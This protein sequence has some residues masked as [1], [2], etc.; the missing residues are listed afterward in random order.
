MIGYMIGLL[1]MM[2]GMVGV[3]LAQALMLHK[4]IGFQ[5][6]VNPLFKIIFNL[7]LIPIFGLMGISLA[8]S[9]MNILATII[10][11]VGLFRYLRMMPK[12][13]DFVPY[14]KIAIGLLG[15]SGI[16]Y[17]LKRNTVITDTD[18]GLEVGYMLLTIFIG[19][20]VYWAGCFLLGLEEARTILK[21][22]WKM[23]CGYTTRR[24][25]S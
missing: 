3:R 10:I 22:V 19:I 24:L 7:I 25:R 17:L 15:L 11:L 8:T 13:S 4:F 20:V 23:L 6:M 5:G 18:F 21:V 12:L 1:P 14:L 9:G 2:V 16:V